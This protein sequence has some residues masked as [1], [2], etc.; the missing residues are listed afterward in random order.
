MHVLTTTDPPSPHIHPPH[1]VTRR[2][3]TRT[4][5]TLPPLSTV[6]CEPNLDG[7]AFY[8][9][10]TCGDQLVRLDRRRGHRPQYLCP[11]CGHRIDT[12]VADRR[13]W[14]QLRAEGFIP[15]FF[16]T[17]PTARRTLLQRLART[18][19]ITV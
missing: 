2:R 17:T 5:G 13:V 8:P 19:H 12:A 18:I 9:G 11:Q 15:P 10:T 7:I 4:T 1:T 16:T 3:F 14:R 6:A